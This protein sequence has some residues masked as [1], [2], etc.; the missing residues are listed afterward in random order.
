MN[1]AFGWTRTTKSTSEARS[2]H[3]RI[4]SPKI[5]IV[6]REI[7]LINPKEGCPITIS[8][9]Y[10]Q[11][12]TSHTTEHAAVRMSENATVHFVINSRHYRKASH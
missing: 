4:L 1:H 9:S 7:K 10:V 8:Q 2:H 3:I 5:R 11:K 12:S 6:L